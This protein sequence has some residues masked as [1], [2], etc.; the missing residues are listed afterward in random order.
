VFESG[1]EKD[2]GNPDRCDYG[3]DIEEQIL[4]SPDVDDWTKEQSNVADGEEDAE[5]GWSEADEGEM[6]DADGVCGQINLNSEHE[7]N[8]EKCHGDYPTH[9]PGGGD[10]AE[11]DGHAEGVDNVVE[12]EAVSG[13]QA[14]ADTGERAVEA[15]AKPIES[16]PENDGEEREPVPSR[17]PVAEPS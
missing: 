5:F 3:A 14:V 17:V 6:K 8:D 1:G 4:A 12:V 9:V 13:T 16:E 2:D 7:I 10:S 11:E 15:V